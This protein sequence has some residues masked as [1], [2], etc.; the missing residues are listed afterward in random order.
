MKALDFKSVVIGVLLALLLAVAL[1]ADRPTGPVGTYQIT[2]STG[3][4]GDLYLARIDTASGEVETWRMNSSG[5]K[6]KN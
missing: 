6:H 4:R 3:S 5:F 1:G 2:M